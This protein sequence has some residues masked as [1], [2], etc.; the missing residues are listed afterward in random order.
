[1][2][3][4]ELIHESIFHD[5][6]NIPQHHYN[7]TFEHSQ[8][9]HEGDWHAPLG[10]CIRSLL[11]SKAW[12]GAIERV[13]FDRSPDSG[14]NLGKLDSD[15]ALSQNILSMGCMSHRHAVRRESILDESERLH[16]AVS[17]S[18]AKEHGI[19]EREGITTCAKSQKP[20]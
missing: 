9:V 19:S 3:L 1:M 2:Y 6:A 20:F 17:E 10:L 16:N 5:P 18:A 7:W 8:F 14:T 13:T 11:I 15:T 4:T 12:T